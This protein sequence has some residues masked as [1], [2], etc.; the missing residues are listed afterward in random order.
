MRKIY[1]KSARADKWEQALL[2]FCSI[3]PGLDSELRQLQRNNYVA[4]PVGTK[5]A[6][7]KALCDSQFD[8]NL[9][10]KE[11]VRL[12][13]HIISKE[14]VFLLTLS[15]SSSINKIFDDLR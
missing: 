7:L 8:C 4:V 3:A 5:L 11:N 14:N 12:F 13:T 1:L 15:V 6:V 2:K 10:F 9:K